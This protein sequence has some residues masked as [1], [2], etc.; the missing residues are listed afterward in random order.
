MTALLPRT[1]LSL[2]ALPGFPLVEPG[3]DLGA[4]ILGAL[5]GGQLTLTDDD[6]LV[7]AQ[8]IV[9]KAEN[10]YA[11]LNDIEP[12][13]AAL[14]LAE[15]ADKDPRIAELILRESTEVLRLR[16]GA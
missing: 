2:H 10:R 6:V 5:D 15:M 13:T 12:S 3:D 4:L 7:L 9:S 8:K 11:Y 1:S 14:E 16:R